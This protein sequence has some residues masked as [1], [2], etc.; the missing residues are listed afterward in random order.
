MGSIATEEE[1]PAA[2]S[3][4]LQEL[5][6]GSVSLET[7]EKAFGPASL[8]I[9]I[10]SGLPEE[11]AA[12]RRRVLSYASYL[13]NLPDE[14]LGMWRLVFH[15]GFLRADVLL[16]RK[17]KGPKRTTMSAGPAGRKLSRMDSLI[18]SRALTTC[19]RYT[20]QSWRRKR[21]SYIP[22]SRT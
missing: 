2:V 12:L 13:A 18:R 21:E 15:N 8:G 5:K 10:V 11:F 4:S 1:R 6:D 20:T 14:E 19:S 16:Q 7:L 17:S 3:V 9:I 22:R